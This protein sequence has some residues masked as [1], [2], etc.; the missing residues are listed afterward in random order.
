V[1]TI[2]GVLV[3]TRPGAAA[4]VAARLSDLAG[5]TVAG[6]DGDSRVAAVWEVTDGARLEAEAERILAEDGE[7]LGIY[8]TFVGDDEG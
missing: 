7:V 3:V 4:R 6:G 8:P 2:A 5:F 1:S